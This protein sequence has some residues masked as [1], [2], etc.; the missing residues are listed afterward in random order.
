MA[1]SD[2]IQRDVNRGLAW[3]GLAASWVSLLDVIANVV[4]L[5]LWISPAQYGV[6]ALAIT[7]FP[8]LDL[9]ADLGL[10]AAVI[11]RDDHT[12]AKIS[13]VFWLNVVMS[14]FL[15]AV[16]ALAVGPLLSLL[17]GEPIVGLMLTAYGGKLIW[18]N[19]YTMPKALMRRQLR[20]KEIAGVRSIA[21]AIEFA[22]KIGVA[23]GGG[24]IW[25]FVIG[26]LAREIGWAAGIQWC[27]PWR[28]R[29]VMR[30]GEAASWAWFGIRQSGSQVLF[31]AYTNV[32]YQLVGHYFG[33]AANGFYRLAY[34]IVLEP[35]RILAMIVNQVAF[36]AYSRLK[37]RRRELIEQFIAL[38]RLNL[39]VVL[40]FVAIILVAAD[41]IVAVLWGP[42]WMPAATAA[43]ILCAVGALRA[44]SFLI[45]PLLEGMGHPG[46]SLAYNAVAAVVLPTCFVVAAEVLG[47]DLGFVSVAVAWAVGYPIAFA[48]LARLAL[49]LL[50]L[51]ATEYL[52]R[53]IGIPGC[54][55]LAAA[56]AGGVHFLA[57]PLSPGLRLALA[58][59]TLLAVFF[60]ALALWQGISPRSVIAAIRGHE[61]TGSSKK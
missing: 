48:V 36:P 29:L 7:L 43:R 47:D 34:D 19:V 23:A 39:V 46:R 24:G 45:P 28:P 32:D 30:I 50:D 56:A 15:F 61:G 57:A 5:A 3:F 20:F 8:V 51:D 14:V 60:P 38:T 18:Q 52:R 31:H 4:I 27:H 55:A 53:V 49:G 44:L 41:D 6:A 17:H 22:V 9:A 13:T 12:E 2:T 16:L 11:Q 37:H 58:T 26:P 42:E 10:S 35:C 59:A 21:N 33:A 1:G 40:G 54:A 25:C